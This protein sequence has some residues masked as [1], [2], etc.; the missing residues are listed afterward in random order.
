ML[1]LFS[2]TISIFIM[3]IFFGG[4]ISAQSTNFGLGMIVGNPTG[5]SA[6]YWHNRTNALDFG[7]GYS[8]SATYTNFNF[9][10][11]YLWHESDVF[12]SRETLYLYYGAGVRLKSV[13][14]GDGSLGVR[15]VLGVDWFLSRS[16]LEFFIEAAPVLRIIP[17]TTMDV[18]AGLG[19]RYYF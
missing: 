1:K 15:A 10:A 3:V 6:K 11:D 14:G 16:P 19:A 17:A 9:H 4:N 8:F 2:R 18:D 12:R 7:L 13:T 5:I